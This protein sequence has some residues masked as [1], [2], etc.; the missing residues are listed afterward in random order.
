MFGSS[1]IKALLTRFTLLLSLADEGV[2]TRSLGGDC[3]LDSDSFRKSIAS[4]RLSAEDWELLKTNECYSVTPGAFHLALANL[5]GLRRESFIMDPEVDREFIHHPV[6]SYKSNVLGRTKDSEGHD[7]LQIS[8][9][10]NFV[11]SISLHSNQKQKPVLKSISY[12]YLLEL[13]ETGEIVGGSWQETRAPQLT[14][15]QNRPLFTTDDKQLEGLYTLSVSLPQRMAMRDFT[16][17]NTSDLHM[18]VSVGEPFL[19]NKKYRLELDG[20]IPR[21]ADRLRVF[22][23]AAFKSLGPHSIFRNSFAD[24]DTL[25]AIDVQFHRPSSFAAIRQ[26]VQDHSNGR[27]TIKRILR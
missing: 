23:Q 10:V 27:S 3:H 20:D 22:L 6:V 9:V 19:T 18:P 13:D 4:R 5:I 11:D 24:E 12:R 2:E 7:T 14:W 25:M 21:G 16:A 17:I 1:D 26:A 8:A 15:M